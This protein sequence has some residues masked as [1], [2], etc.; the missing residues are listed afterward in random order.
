MLIYEQPKQF[1]Y[2]LL[3]SQKFMNA[4]DPLENQYTRRLRLFLYLVPVVGCLPAC[5]TLYRRAGNE[6][7]QAVSRLAVTLALAWLLGYFLLGIGAQEIEFLKIRLL[8]VDSLMTSGYFLVSLWLMLRLWQH[9]SVR[10]PG[11]SN[12]SKRMFR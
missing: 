11:L 12:L 5:W 7:E 9:Q 4:P 6:Q 2:I 1:G 8:I 3:K 10:L